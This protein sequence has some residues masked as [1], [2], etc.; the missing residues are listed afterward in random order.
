MNYNC[1]IHTETIDGRSDTVE[2]PRGCSFQPGARIKR[3]YRT[4]VDGK[5][6]TEGMTEERKDFNNDYSQE[7]NINSSTIRETNNIGSNQNISRMDPMFTSNDGFW[8]SG[9]DNGV[10]TSQYSQYDPGLPSQTSGPADSYL[11]QYG[12]G[13]NNTTSSTTTTT[14]GRPP[15]GG[16]YSESKVENSINQTDNCKETLEKFFLWPGVVSFLIGLISLV[17]IYGKKYDKNKDFNGLGTN[18]IEALLWGLLGLLLFAFFVGGIAL[19]A[20]HKKFAHDIC[21]K[22]KDNN[23]ATSTG[24]VRDETTVNRES[25]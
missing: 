11:S 7:Q 6:K 14:G 25:P 12:M 24:Y 15:Q 10:P 17:I 22:Q 20:G 13:D 21:E 23:Q 9:M 16:S 18:F 1:T 3:T 8:S 2:T 19:M 5:C 4:C